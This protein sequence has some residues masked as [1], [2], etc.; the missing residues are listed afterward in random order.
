MHARASASDVRPHLSAHIVLQSRRVPRRNAIGP[1]PGPC[2][3]ACTCL[4]KLITLPCNMSV[5]IP[6]PDPLLNILS[7]PDREMTVNKPK[8]RP[9]FALSQRTIQYHAM[10]AD[11]PPELLQYDVSTLTTR[12]SI[13]NPPPTHLAASAASCRRRPLAPTCACA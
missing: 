11:L 7:F 9:Y 3:G 1:S 13:D 2:C 8:T 6:I 4:S 10:P 5:S 12:L